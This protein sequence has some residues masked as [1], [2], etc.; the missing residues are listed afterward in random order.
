MKTKA[1]VAL[2]VALLVVVS[3]CI[4]GGTQEKSTP[5]AT[6]QPHEQSETQTTSSAPTNTQR[7]AQDQTNL[8]TVNFSELFSKVIQL[9]LNPTVIEK[10]NLTIEY[11]GKRI[12]GRYDFVI[13]NLS[14]SVFYLGAMGLPDD[15][16]ALILN[17]SI[18]G[19]PLNLSRLKGYRAGSEE[20]YGT[21]IKPSYLIVYEIPVDSSKSSIK[22][23]ITYSLKYPLF[24][25]DFWQYAGSPIMGFSITNSKSFGLNL[26]YSLPEGYSLVIPGYGVLT[27]SGRISGDRLMDSLHCSFIR[28]GEIVSEKFSVSGINVT[29]YLAS[30]QYVP[31]GWNKTIALIKQAIG[32]YYNITGVRPVN[33]TYIVFNPDFSRSFAPEPEM[34]IIIIGGRSNIRI[35]YERKPNSLPHE[36]A[37]LWF[38]GYVG[39]SPFNEGFATYFETLAIQRFTP[40]GKLYLKRQE[41]NIEKYGTISINEAYK[42]TETGQHALNMS[43][44]VVI[45]QKVNFFLRSLQYLLGDETFSKGIH[46][47]L[48]RCHGKEYTL[49]DIQK[50]FEKAS[51]K[52]LDWFFDEWINSIALPDYKVTQLKISENGGGYNLTFTITDA[53]NFTMPVPIRIYL[54]NGEYLDERIWVNGTATVS[55]ELPGKPVKI[56]IDPEEV[57]A[58]VNRESRVNDVAVKVD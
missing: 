39:E 27:G 7:E 24:L 18:E 25:D 41:D 45:Y 6:S 57:M 49:T 22:G 9:S 47:L 58:N 13:S 17:V 53:N 56:V 48:E 52:D 43:V 44:S 33:S 3:G 21:R 23:T 35:L 16:T 19:T 29:V 30:S 46:T 28:R 40:W 14:E 5:S 55:L 15:P 12:H 8:K 4:G 38:A 26:T 42:L 1:V 51:G 10:G 50:S 54:E 34:G 2:L 36:L 31:E 11:D 20:V 37:H 32:L